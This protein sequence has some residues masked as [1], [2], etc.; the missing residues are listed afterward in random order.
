M[1]K[2]SVLVML[3][4]ACGMMLPSLANLP[5]ED[6][7]D[8]K[9]DKCEKKGAEEG[10]GNNDGSPGNTS[11]SGGTGD[12]KVDSVSILV[13]WGAPANENIVG[14]YRFSIYTKK[15]TPMIYSPQIIQYRNLLL[16]R[17]SISEI[18]QQYKQDIRGDKY[19]SVETGYNDE[20]VVA[21]ISNGGGQEKLM[22]S[23]PSNVTH[24]IRIFT[25]DREMMTFQF[26]TGSSV[27]TMV[28]ETST[29]NNL[30]KMVNANGEPTTTNPVYY[31]RYLGQG[32]F[33]R[34]SAETGNVVSYHTAMGRVI[35]P[36]AL[37]VGIEPIYEADGTVRQVWS[38]G[39]GL[40]DIVVT[41]A[42]VSYEI[43][44][45]SP[46]K[47]GAKVDGLYTVTGEPHTVWR[48]E[49]PT[50]GTNTK[51]KV[52]KTVNG[53]AEVSLFEYSHNAEGWLLR[54][55]G[56]LAIESQSTSWDY[57]QTVKV[58]T[59]VDK[60]P[61]GQVASKVARTYQ[62]YAFGDRVVNVSVDPDGANLRTTTTYYTDSGNHGSYGRKKTESFPDGNWVSYEYDAQGRE[63][64]K[65]TPWKNAAFNSPAAQAKAEYKN[66]SPHDSRDIVEN[67]DIRPRTEETRILGITTSKTYHA[68]YFDGNEYVEIEER[69]VNGNAEYGDATNLRT[70]RR[71]YPKGNCSSPSAGRIH[72]IKYPNGT[73]DTYTYEYGTWTPNSDPAQSIFTPGS[74]IAVRVKITHG[75][76]D[77]P[78]GIAN[79]TLQDSTVY[80]SR[81]CRVYL[82]QAVY[83]ADGY[84]TFAWTANT[85]DE[86]RRRI[87]ERKS[88]NELTEYTWNCCDKASEI[89]PDGT[90]YT[91][92]YDDLKRLISKTKVG[93]GN[94]PD[95]VTAYQ[96]DAANRKIS[97]TITGG[98]LSTMATWEYNLAGQLEKE[99]NH[100]GLITTYTYVQGINSGSNCKGKTTT[101]TNPGGFTT[102][103]QTYC[104]GQLS[105]ITGTAQVP[106]YYDAGINE[107]GSLWN[108]IYIGR[109]DSARWSKTTTNLLNFVILNEKSGFNGIVTQQSFYNTKNQLIKTT[110]TGSAP[111][112]FEYNTLGN[113]VRSGLDVDNNGTLDL[114]SDDFIADIEISIDNSWETVVN[115][116]YGTANSATATTFSVKK[117][118]LSGFAASVVAE[119]Q[120]IDI[121]GN[122]TTQTQMIDRSN[123]TTTVMAK[124]PASSVEARAIT[125]N[126]LKMSERSTSNLTTTYAYDGLE[127]LVSVTEPRIGVTTITYHTTAG[128]NG[129][130]AT[131]TNAAGNMTTY[132]YDTTTG[133]LLWKKNALN[134]Y[135]RYAYNAYGQLTNIWGDTQYPVQFGYDQFGQNTTMRTYRMNAAWNGTTWPTDVIGDLTTWTYDEA[136]GLVTAKTAANNKSVTYTYTVDG[137]LATRTWARGIVTTY[138]YSSTTGKLL[139]VDYT[140]DTPDITYTYNRLG[141][142]VTI[143]DVAGTRMF[144][145]NSTF[146][147]IKETINGIYSKEINRTYTTSGM[148][149]RISGMSIGDVQN[150]IY[151]Y[152]DYGR[153]NKISTPAGEFNYTRLDNSDLVSQMTRPNG[154]TTTWSYE[155]NRNLIT[156]VQNGTISIF[157]YTNNAIGNR[158]SVS[159]SGSAFATPDTLNYTYNS[160]GEVTGAT[161]DE[162]AA[163]NYAYNFDPIGNRLTASL[164]GIGY[165]YTANALNQYTA[166]TSGNI[167]SDPTYDFDGNMLT[168]D[169]WTQ[170]WNGENRLTEMVRNDTRL[171][172]SYDYLGRRIEKKVYKKNNGNWLIQKSIKF[173]Y[174]GYKLIEEIDSINN[175]AVIHRYIWQ[176]DKLGLDVPL[177]FYNLAHERNYY[178]LFDAN[179]NISELTEGD[180]VSISYRYDP[181]GQEIILH[182]NNEI[183]NPFRFSG[184]YFDS[185]T[186][187]VYYNYRYY[188]PQLGRWIN[189]DPIEEKDIINLYVMVN[190]DPIGLWDYLGM[191]PRGRSN[192]KKRQRKK[193]E[194]K[195]KEFEKIQK[196]ANCILRALLGLLSDAKNDPM[197]QKAFD[198]AEN[199]DWFKNAAEYYLNNY[200][201]PKNWNVD[202]AGIGGKGFNPIIM[203]PSIASYDF[204]DGATGILP[205]LI[206][207]PQHN[208]SQEGPGH[209][210]KINGK[211]KDLDTT[212]TESL[213][214]LKN[215]AGRQKAEGCCEKTNT[216]IKNL[217]DKI[218]CDCK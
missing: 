217:W 28:G 123:K 204:K 19:T 93:I 91:Y 121:H 118:R 61:E 52:T 49:N 110:Q 191:S 192:Y 16:D 62:K 144:A 90:Q 43:R 210:I 51:I 160:R 84:E 131:V 95:L 70:E 130:K 34:Y 9:C 158:I 177:I 200:S 175:D 104:S 109:A 178:Y 169:G 190:N 37:T 213:T 4:I 162:N 54:K 40:A 112:L 138:T 202:G 205:T 139:N 119:T 142:Q 167:T 36:N 149:G 71:Y 22:N 48:I 79:K 208:F 173:V 143:Q 214:A 41:E 44:C 196:E 100:Q 82:T 103:E 171:T 218:Q 3:L 207:E 151:S 25:A 206:H 102:I 94:Q 18:N 197:L 188:D 111:T 132:D 141:Q 89:L 181:F 2:L 10:G 24:Q 33:L 20:K 155:L 47:V 134:Q 198:F 105:A 147:L 114:A 161:S 15:P 199:A 65:I 8:K 83:T 92:I 135:T 166:I 39:D 14:N 163:Y 38:L 164:T 180:V 211:N 64:V 45:Y 80:D 12:G 29:M 53:V 74:G 170:T 193:Q 176:P 68:Y 122:V 97:E 172:F 56:D 145:Y 32:N 215:Y 21:V 195:E 98:A 57:S 216:P 209:T 11:N 17:I 133:W 194:Q 46:D 108:K 125:I 189:R 86:L 99:T 5:T 55:P 58:I 156:Q 27:G 50:P 75:T 126:G 66:F 113:V 124:T 23:L 201:S 184:E 183:L 185:E 187:L 146:D 59:T 26:K 77:S 137:K 179:K 128:K 76:V 107:D 140:D 127:R 7:C 165:N 85:F 101:I 96:Y 78:A 1:K 30:L 136:S 120:I 182:E 106:E 117:Q 159:R 81:G 67:D 60:T 168:R 87:S 212:I 153:I 73:M 129:L 148:K 72:T 115:K 157:D 116:V 31:D 203:D 63:I 13:N 152:D 186:A 42:A 150:Y 69:C 174:D 6:G 154:A 35:T 88:N